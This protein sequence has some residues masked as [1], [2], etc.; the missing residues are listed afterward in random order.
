MEIA[1]DK[2][3][4]LNLTNCM[5]EIVIALNNEDGIEPWLI[6]GVPDGTRGPAEI[7]EEFEYLTEEDF[8]H[9]WILFVRIVKRYGADGIVASKLIP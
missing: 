1:F 9:L 3:Q 6:G 2:K 4:A 8:E 7:A 5:N